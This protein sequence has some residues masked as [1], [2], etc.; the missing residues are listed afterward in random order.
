MKNNTTN[1]LTRILLF[2]F[3]VSSNTFGQD[4]Q[5]LA[6][7]GFQFL[8]VGTSARSAAL[9]EAFTTQDGTSIAMFHNPAGLSRMTSSS[10][11][12]ISQMTWIADINYYS[13]AVALNLGSYGVFGLSLKYVDYG[14]FLWTQVDPTS[15]KGYSDFEG[16]G[17]PTSY[18]AGISYAKDLSDKF[19]VGGTIKYA[20]QNLGTSYVPI[21][22]I[23]HE[24]ILGIDGKDSIETI[25]GTQEYIK[26]VFA[27]DFGTIYKTGFKSLAFGMSIRNFASEQKYVKESFQLPLVFRIGISMN[28]LD[29]FDSISD[30]NKFNVSIDA[31]HPRS[32]PEYLSIGGEYNFSDLLYLRLGYITSQS[33]YSYSLGAGITHF[34]VSF[35]YAYTPFDTFS[36][37]NRFA[38]GFAF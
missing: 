36:D 37:V 32:F 15:E 7:T 35:N 34:G 22:H 9:G 24:G 23:V 6:Q 33:D 29:F 8:T 28:V 18:M 12:N 11:V 38:V 2:I 21:D 27:F 4:N 1:V 10:E 14:E 5:K 13:G 16:W 30:V 20:N 25:I 17:M 19:A 26:G 31:V 3:L